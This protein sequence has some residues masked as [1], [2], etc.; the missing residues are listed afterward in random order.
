MWTVPALIEDTKVQCAGIL[1]PTI[2]GRR[3]ASLDGI[4]LDVT[5]TEARK[6][7][8][9]CTWI[10]VIAVRIHLTTVG[11]GV[12]Y[13]DSFDAPVYGAGVSFHTIPVDRAFLAGALYAHRAGRTHRVRGTTAWIGR[14]IF[15]F[16]RTRQ[17]GTD[18]L[19]AV[20]GAPTQGDHLYRNR[21]FPL[22]RIHGIPIQ[23]Q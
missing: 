4:D 13:T 1:I 3:A 11:D 10:F 15:A 14:P 8:I 16:R 7:D 6:A 18:G 2:Q 19:V 9:D 23:I 21:H 17:V 20:A 12:M 22:F 5:C